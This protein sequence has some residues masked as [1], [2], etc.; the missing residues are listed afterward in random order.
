[1]VTTGAGTT[2]AD[3]DA[4]GTGGARP[5][6]AGHRPQQTFERIRSSAVMARAAQRSASATAARFLRVK[7]PEPADYEARVRPD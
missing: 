6:V 2:E 4:G 5:R 3:A 7:Q 1:M